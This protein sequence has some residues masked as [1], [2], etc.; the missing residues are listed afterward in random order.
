[1]MKFKTD[2]VE[3]LKELRKLISEELDNTKLNVNL[4]S[5]VAEFLTEVTD[6][7]RSRRLKMVRRA[8]DEWIDEIVV[9]KRKSNVK[10]DIH[11]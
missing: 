11:L 9:E 8:L 6:R 5:E 10:T 4:E 1:M 2:K 3:L 7:R